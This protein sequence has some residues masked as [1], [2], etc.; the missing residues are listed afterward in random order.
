LESYT[1]C[2]AAHSGTQQIDVF[3]VVERMFLV[4]D[5][6]FKITLKER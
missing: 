2:G 3:T 1:S 5:W 4:Q 6:F